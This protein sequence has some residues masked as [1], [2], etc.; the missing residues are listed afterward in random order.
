MSISP[1]KFK[2][3]VLQHEKSFKDFADKVG[4]SQET[5][6]RMARGVNP[7]TD[8]AVLKFARVYPD[9]AEYF[10]DEAIKS[11]VMEQAGIHGY[12]K[13]EKQQLA[14]KLKQWYKKGDQFVDRLNELLMEENTKDSQ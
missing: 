5:I 14:K 6:A 13:N 11:L 1:D 2:A 7:I 12:A 8:R 4:Y 3:F 10:P 9:I